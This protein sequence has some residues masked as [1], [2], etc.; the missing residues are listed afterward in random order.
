MKK[1]TTIALS[2]AVA[3]FGATAV[4]QPSALDEGESVAIT[5]Q[6][7]PIGE[8]WTSLSDATLEVTNA[9]G[10]IPD[11]GKALDTVNHFANVDYDVTVELDGGSPPAETRFHIMI[12]IQNFADFDTSMNV[13]AGFAGQTPAVADAEFTWT[14]GQ[15]TQH[16]ALSNQAPTASANQTSV[17]YAIEARDGMPA[18]TN[19]N[20]DVV[21]TI[22]QN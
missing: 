3:M 9:Y 13:P 1:F 15:T 14:P 7:G 8:L 21:W 11:E 16:T 4:A 19:T 5:I 22:T 10:M 6:V 12:G 18:N 17:A 2:A 20:F